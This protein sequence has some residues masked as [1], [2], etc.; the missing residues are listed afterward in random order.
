MEQKK[1]VTVIISVGLVLILLTGLGY[2]VFA[3]RNADAYQ[4]ARGT[5]PTSREAK[6]PVSIDAGEWA[7]NENAT[8]GLSPA[9]N[10]PGAAGA[11]AS[12]SNS[13]DSPSAGSNTAT[14]TSGNVIF[15][16]GERPES[17]VGSAELNTRDDGTMVIDLSGA[18]R[19]NQ[20]PNEISVKPAGEAKEA[21]SSAAAQPA[22]APAAAAARPAPAARPAAP[23]PAAPRP[24]AASARPASATAPARTSLVE[25]YFVQAGAYSSKARADAVK[26]QLADR[27]IGAI[28]EVREIDSKTFFRV[29]V[30]PYNTK[31]EADYW[32]SLIKT[33]DG[34]GESYVSMTRVRR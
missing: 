30:G 17:G 29:R 27:K 10:E 2:F 23:R 31:S 5:R 34:F 15:I 22:P 32:L 18:P 3:P 13:A 26:A 24:A 16:Y 14:S 25:Q 21:R 7:R 33:L 6:R 1:L 28:V 9:E 19:P 8:P 4:L 11:N 12:D 20:K